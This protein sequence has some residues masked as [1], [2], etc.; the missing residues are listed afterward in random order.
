M[1]K[2]DQIREMAEIAYNA[3]CIQIGGGDFV[4]PGDRQAAAEIV[5]EDLYNASYGDTKQALKEFAEKFHDRCLSGLKN[6]VW[7]YGEGAMDVINIF[8]DLVK[9]VCGE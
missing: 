4:E 1:N 5:S 7:E 8:D 6:L 9:E 3:I 2:E